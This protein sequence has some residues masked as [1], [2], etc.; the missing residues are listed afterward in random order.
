MS[1][2]QGRVALV[3]GAGRGIGAAVAKRLASDGAKVAVVDLNESVCKD[4]V[5]AIVESG[6][7]AVGIACDVSIREQVDTAVDQAVTE[8]G[9]LDVLVNNAGV[10]R[11]SLLFKMADDDWDVVLDVNLKGAFH[12][13]RAVQRYMVERRWGKIVNLSSASALGKRG[14]ANYASA[15]AGI[16]GLTRTLALELGPFNVN[17]NAVAPGFVETAMTE[18]TA[19]RQGV[20][21]ERF[22]QG[23]IE[24]TPLRRVGKPED[25]AGVVSFLCSE[26]SSFVSG[27]TIY[28][29]GGPRG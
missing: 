2:L 25:I 24:R 26:D 11:D 21:F 13:A 7:L 23:A 1:S 18:A 15:K 3:T 10:T 9:W 29:A 12:C 28:A 14:Q 4:T 27:Q 6:G 22:K 20:E 16:Q 17:A 5:E 19:V 8:L